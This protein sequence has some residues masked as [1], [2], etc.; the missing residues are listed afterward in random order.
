MREN[1]QELQVKRY[2]FNINKRGNHITDTYCQITKEHMIMKPNKIRE[3]KKKR[4][5]GKDK[6]QRQKSIFYKQANSPRLCCLAKQTRNRKENVNVPSFTSN[7]SPML[8]NIQ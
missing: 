6:E 5:K 4:K 1:K 3:N 2:K 7:S 8:C